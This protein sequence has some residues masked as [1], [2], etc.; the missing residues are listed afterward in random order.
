MATQPYHNG[1]PPRR[2]FHAVTLLLLHQ[3]NTST[4]NHQSSCSVGMTPVFYRSSSVAQLPSCYVGPCLDNLH[5][6]S[7]EV[8]HRPWIFSDWSD[9]M[10]QGS[11]GADSPLHG[12]IVPTIS[13]SLRGK[14]TGVRFQ[15]TGED[16]RVQ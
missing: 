12:M 5:N 10:Q 2:S 14:T 15:E 11:Q 3:M 4:P 9:S 6:V 8:V 1:D 7:P 16:G 13:P